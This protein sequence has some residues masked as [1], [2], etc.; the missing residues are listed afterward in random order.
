MVRDVQTT[1][2][3]VVLHVARTIAIRTT[4]TIA[5]AMSHS[6]LTSGGG[7]SDISRSYRGRSKCRVLVDQVIH[8]VDCPATSVLAATIN[9]VE[10]DAPR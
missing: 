6:F 9:R 10:E 4:S 8:G 7:F 3:P 2:T 5:I 1:P